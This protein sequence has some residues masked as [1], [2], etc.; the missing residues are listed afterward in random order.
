MKRQVKA[1]RKDG[2][3]F[4]VELGV[5]E[6]TV[7]ATKVNQINS[8]DDGSTTVANDDAST[9]TASTSATGTGSTSTSTSS[10]LKKK[11]FCGYMRDLTQQKKDKRALRK[12]QQLIHGK[13]FGL[14]TPKEGQEYEPSKEGEEKSMK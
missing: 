4:D 2:S 14:E 7:R 9:L 3:E 12:Q 13:F 10:S 8:S 6:V 11:V 5:Q 1:R